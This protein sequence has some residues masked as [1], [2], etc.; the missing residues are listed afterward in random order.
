MSQQL[1]SENEVEIHP[2]DILRDIL[3]EAGTL[4]RLMEIH[5][6]V[7]EPGM[8]DIMRYLTGLSDADRERLLTFL[9]AQ[10]SPSRLRV[11]EEGLGV[12]R[13]QYDSAFVQRTV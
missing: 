5:Y 6:V 8:L 13:L 9:E 7:Q 4:S 10:A 11:Q 1:L 12:L 2:I 3:A